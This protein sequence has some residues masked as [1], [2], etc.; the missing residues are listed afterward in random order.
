MQPTCDTLSCNGSPI[1]QHL[2]V[3][4]QLHPFRLCP[5]SLEKDLEVAGYRESARR[6]RVGSNVPCGSL[7]RVLGGPR[8]NEDELV[9][10][11]AKLSVFQDLCKAYAR[12]RR[13]VS[14]M[15]GLLSDSVE[16]V[17]LHPCQ[18]MVA[19]TLFASKV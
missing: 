9:V 15:P 5:S 18:A 3:S 12:F 13:H 8:V 2:G 16:G 14:I 7:L 17:Y 1:A 11:T 19:K 6:S 10:A 4:V